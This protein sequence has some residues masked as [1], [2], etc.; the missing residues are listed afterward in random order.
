[1]EIVLPALTVAFGAFCVWLGVRIFNRRERWAKW[2]AVGLAVVAGYPLSWG[3]MVFIL[4]R[5]ALPGW[6]VRSI[7]AIY[8]PLFWLRWDGPEPFREA[9]DWYEKTWI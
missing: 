2:T 8:Q 9:L 3:P 5:W 7:S 1:M 6:A 4:T